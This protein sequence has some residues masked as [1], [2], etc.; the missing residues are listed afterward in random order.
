MYRLVIT[1]NSGYC[2]AFV[3]RSFSFLRTDVLSR[4]GGW[5]GTAL[6]ALFPPRTWRTDRTSFQVVGSPVSASFPLASPHCA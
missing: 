4:I 3:F 1:P 5:R 6:A 2:L